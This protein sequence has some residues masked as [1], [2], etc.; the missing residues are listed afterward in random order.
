MKANLHGAAVM[1]MTA[2]VTMMLCTSSQGQTAAPSPNPAA[3]Q[4]NDQTSG[5]NTTNPKANGGQLEQV[6]VTGYLIPRIGEGPQPV[7][8]LNQD[9]IQKQAYQTVNDVRRTIYPDLRRSV[10]LARLKEPASHLG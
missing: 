9:F 3:G 10:V 6:T 8:T 4:T 1:A 2:A 7:A 5:A